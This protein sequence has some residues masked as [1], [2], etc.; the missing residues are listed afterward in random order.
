MVLAAVVILYV[1][2][3]YLKGGN[4]FSSEKSYYTYFAQITGVEKSS[5]IT[6]NG[7]QVGQ[8][9]NLRLLPERNY[10]VEVQLTFPKKM[11][12][13]Q[14]TVVELRSLGVLG[15]KE[16]VLVLPKEVTGGTPLADGDTITSRIRPTLTD[17][18]DTPSVQTDLGISISSLRSLMV[19]LDSAGPSV[20]RMLS[21][22]D[23]LTA[24]LSQFMQLNQQAFGQGVQQLSRATYKLN[25]TISQVDSLLLDLRQGVRDINPGE[26]GVLVHELKRSVGSLNV[27]FEDIHAGKGTLGKLLVQD[28]LYSELTTMLSGVHI[29]LEHINSRPRDFVSPFGRSA[30]RIARAKEKKE[31]KH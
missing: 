13:P 15:G 17:L 2:V 18:I 6:L 8:V 12:I 21:N 16:I 30:R 22:I 24:T 5:P 25:G 7:L 28:T 9:G 3:S 27:V 19:S 14:G 26:V 29:L 4:V 10:V 31:K 1:G 20:V 11:S 23:T